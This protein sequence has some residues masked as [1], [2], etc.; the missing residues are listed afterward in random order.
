MSKVSIFIFVLFIAALAVFAI[1]NQEV[2]TVKIPF[3]KTYETPTIALVLLSGAVGALVMLLVF[4][5]RD[6]K[7]FLDSWQYQKKQK[8]EAKAQELYSKAVNYLQAHHNQNDAKELL[9][10]VLTE[11]PE[12]LN[13][14]LQLGD[15]A[16]SEDD[17]QGAR[18]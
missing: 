14:M 10:E 11:E 3:G 7:R 6:T 15:I 9:K 4:V 17:F 5:V 16:F 18:E 2:T 12:H 13:A 1:F 8:K